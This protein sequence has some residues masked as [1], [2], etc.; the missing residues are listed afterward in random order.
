MQF[1]TAHTTK[2]IKSERAK[3]TESIKPNPFDH[4]KILFHILT[5]RPQTAFNQ[6]EEINFKRSRL[7]VIEMQASK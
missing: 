4:K 7:Q 5:S 3:R 1:N 2:T 6:E